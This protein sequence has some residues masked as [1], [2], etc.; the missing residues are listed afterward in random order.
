MLSG[1]VLGHVRLFVGGLWVVGVGVEGEGRV[2]EEGGGGL[3][4]RKVGVLGA[5]VVVLVHMNCLVMVGVGL[6]HSEIGLRS[7]M[8][9]IWSWGRARGLSIRLYIHREYKLAVHI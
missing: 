7:G 2:G 5:G 6:L 3:R 1:D 4:F 8:Q 9:Y